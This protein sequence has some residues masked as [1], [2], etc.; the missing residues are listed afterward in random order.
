VGANYVPS[1][2]INRFE[3][4]QDA[5]WDRALNA[6]ELALAQSTGMNTIRVFLQDQM[7]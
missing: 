3:M 4:F 6:K 5:A 7:Y 2:A 1:D